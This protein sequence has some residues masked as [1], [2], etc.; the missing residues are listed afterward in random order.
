MCTRDPSGAKGPGGDH[1]RCWLLAVLLAALL[2]PG[3]AAAQAN[4]KL[5]DINVQYLQGTVD[6]NG[7]VRI[8]RITTTPMGG[9]IEFTHSSQDQSAKCAGATQHFTFE[10]E[11]SRNVSILSGN[12]GDP[13]FTMRTTWFSDE[14]T[15]CLDENPWTFVYVHGYGDLDPP[16]FVNP[17]DE[18]RIYPRPDPKCAPKDPT[19]IMR[20][21]GTPRASFDIQPSIRWLG[22]NMVITYV[23]DPLP[24]S[25]TMTV[26]TV[27]QTAVGT[28]TT[29]PG[30]TTPG[31]GGSGGGGCSWTGTW[32]TNYGQMTLSQSGNRVTGTYTWDSGKI[33][34][35]VS[36]NTL[37]GRWSEAPSYTEPNDA[38]QFV[39]TMAPDCNSFTGTVGYGSSSTG[40]SWTGTRPAGL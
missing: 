32:E 8:D 3:L 7:P 28:I 30:G 23:Y 16:E 39:F 22:A 17:C 10:W 36:G 21:K 27:P 2:L 11:F 4:Y 5:A 29:V 12:A 25:P 1:R 6:P 14:G 35:V 20:D 31:T 24:D 19:F 37:T 9:A 38:G 13:Q 15:E 34:G 40:L 26:T 33:E 18:N